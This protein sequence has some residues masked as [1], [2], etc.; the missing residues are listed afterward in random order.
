MMQEIMSQVVANVSE[1]ATA[2]NSSCN[3]PIPVKNGMS[4][5]PERDGEY[6]KKRRW[7]NKAVSIHRKVVVNA[8]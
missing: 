4:E 2:K 7:H 3:M 8:M 5:S 6:D 1:N